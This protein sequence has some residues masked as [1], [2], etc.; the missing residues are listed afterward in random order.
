MSEKSFG[1][2]SL[3]TMHLQMPNGNFSPATKT[4][5]TVITLL[6]HA[7]FR[8]T[9][10]EPRMQFQIIKKNCSCRHGRTC[11]WTLLRQ[12]LPGIDC[13]CINQWSVPSHPCSFLLLLC[14]EK[15]FPLNYGI[16][17]VRIYFNRGF[18][19]RVNF[20]KR[21]ILLLVYIVS[22]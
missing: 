11:A 10:P 5:V 16:H 2:E 20:K 22:A 19:L 1:P 18:I 3:S 13:I 12:Y 8:Y 6:W 7:A 17:E 15:S 21:T 4:L 9:N 14:T